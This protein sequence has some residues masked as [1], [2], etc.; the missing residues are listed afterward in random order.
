MREERSAV[1]EGDTHTEGER[2]RDITADL[3]TFLFSILLFVC[4]NKKS[5]FAVSTPSG[6]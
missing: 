5:R 1:R 6:V 3:K 4:P 2:E